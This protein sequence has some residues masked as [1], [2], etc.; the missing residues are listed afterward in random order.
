MRNVRM[1]KKKKSSKKKESRK[2]HFSS[3]TNG[4]KQMRKTQRDNR[5]SLI[6]IISTIRL[7]KF[8]PCKYRQGL[9]AL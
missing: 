3:I 7:S 6:G 8:Q 4:K 5:N 1:K 2:K 9:I